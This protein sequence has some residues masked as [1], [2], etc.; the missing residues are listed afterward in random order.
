[1]DPLQ[2][3]L[4]QEMQVGLV[5]GMSPGMMAPAAGAGASRF[6]AMAGMYSS[7][8]AGNPLNDPSPL[9]PLNLPQY[10]LG[11]TLAAI[12][13]NAYLNSVMPQYGMLPVGNAGSYMQAYRTRE[14]MN[15]QNQLNFEVA[16]NDAPGIYRTARGIFSLAGMSMDAQQRQMAMRGAQTF[17]G[18][19][20][21]MEPFLPGI[22]DALA[23]PGGSIQMMTPQVL[24]ANRYQ[25]DPRTG[26]MGF[27]IDSNRDY[28]NSMYQT[29]FGADN[30]AKMQGFRAGDIGQLYRELSAEG[31]VSA[32]NLR[33]RTIR[34]LQR[35]RDEG[36]DI[37]A[38]ASQADIRFGAQDNFAALS[39]EDLTKF[40]QTDT[41]RQRLTQSDTQQIA[42]QL[43]GYTDSLAAIREVLGENG[44]QNAPIPKL[45]NHLKA[46]T[47]GQMQKF[48]PS[49]LNNMVRD[50][51]ALS[52]MSGKSIDQMIL[53]NQHANSMNTNILGVHGVHFNQATTNVGVTSGMAF[54]ERGGATGF[55]ALNREQVEQ[56]S[57][58]M[59][60]RSLG[61]EMF[62][63]MGAMT[64]IENAGGFADNE[65]GRAM[66][67]AIRAADMGSAT[68]SYTDDNGK[69]VTANTPTREFE[70][71]AL[72][73]RGAINGMDVSGFN[74]MLGDVTS[75]TRAMATAST[76]RKMAAFNQQANEINSV[77]ELTLVNRLAGDQQL[78]SQIAD[79]EARNKAASRLS[80]VAMNAIDNLSMPQLQDVR[81]RNQ[82]V[83]EALQ[84]EAGNQGLQLSDREAAAMADNAF[85]QRETVLNNRFGMDA[86]GYAMNF[87]KS[88]RDSR[89]EKQSV[90]SATAG[91]N[92][93]MSKLGN[94]GT[95]LQRFVS[96][97]QRQGDRGIKGDLATLFTDTFGQ[98]DLD[99]R[100]EEVAKPMEQI[101]T[102]K[103]TI[104]RL[105]ANL[106]GASPAE[107]EKILTEIEAE[108]KLLDKDVVVAQGIFDE[109]GLTEDKGHFNLEDLARGRQAANEIDQLSRTDAVRLLT[110]TS[111]AK[112]IPAE[113]DVLSRL[114]Q[115][116]DGRKLQPEERNRLRRQAEEQLIAEKQLKAL[117]VAGDTFQL[118]STG[119]AIKSD[120]RLPADLRDELAR[121]RQAGRADVVSRYVD[122]LATEQFYSPELRQ[123]AIKAHNTQ[124]GRQ[125]AADMA[126]NVMA[127]A[128][129]RRSFVTDP[130]A[131]S[132]G[133][134]P[135]LLAANQ[136]KM[137]EEDLQIMANKYFKGNVGR[138]LATGGVAMDE[139]G[140][141]TSE[142]EFAALTEDDKKNIKDRLKA[143]GRD[144][145]QVTSDDYRAYLSLKAKDHVATMR[146]SVNGM[147]GAAE[148]TYA[149]LLKVTDKTRELADRTIK[150]A[151]PEQLAGL[152]AMTTAAGMLGIKLSDITPDKQLGFD[153]NL[154]GGG[155]GVS[156]DHM[157]PKRREFYKLAQGLGGLSKLS[158]TQLDDL[159][160]LAKLSNTD[161]TEDA[162]KLGV[163]VDE[164][165]Q[166]L[167]GKAAPER[168]RLFGGD[169][170]QLRLAKE[171]NEQLAS[172]RNRY[173]NARIQLEREPTSEAA[174]QELNSLTL[175]IQ[176][177]ESDRNKRMRDAGFNPDD[178][179][180][181][182]KYNKMLESQGAVKLLEDRRLKR[183]GLRKKFKDGGV[184]DTA[185][186]SALE[187]QQNLLDLAAEQA[188]TATERDLGDASLNIIADLGGLE[189]VDARKGFLQGLKRGFGSSKNEEMLAS[190]LLRV[191]QVDTGDDRSYAIDKLTKLT[192]E[193]QSKDEAGRKAMAA[194][195]GM[196]PRE[197]NRMM[198]QTS[199]LNLGE[200]KDGERVDLREALNRSAGVDIAEEAK[201]EE[202]KK[203]Y[204]TGGT[205]T[206]QGDVVGQATVNEI[207]AVSGAR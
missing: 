127:L 42:D 116:S 203:M 22:T 150:D 205:L 29:M 10:G 21:T 183:E 51:Q 34:T 142:T 4:L 161:Y 206:I 14:Q 16:Q 112:L 133:G 72:A 91:L 32:G 2:L 115:L 190:A 163:T 109:M 179:K 174:K 11:G 78:V 113:Q 67:A 15:M 184:D 65:A 45:I 135:A 117:G 50:M 189:D 46:L 207:T 90:A 100:A 147:S 108:T 36:V 168:M 28:I 120:Q 18:F 39:N 56:A 27:G 64:R 111:Q 158:K 19:A 85:S 191:G 187:T 61:S 119:E 7:P 44:D 110:G 181:I 97:I 118:N 172:L 192:K 186:D 71:R 62:N 130:Y 134:A 136:N 171:E 99:S 193:F 156:T 128:D 198:A 169:M 20:P 95:I 196:D 24:E 6:N 41:I 96:A 164:Y 143:I 121:T 92:Q 122:S 126:Q 101:R 152:Q 141:K 153:S 175:Q 157:D 31:L 38:L 182:A 185:L 26:R 138:M 104:E 12:A 25:V 81:Q 40:R 68:Y 173:D 86:T 48:D 201:K 144:V 166:M 77:V 43:Q 178:P 98:F 160:A 107:R 80:S 83:A 75:N 54:A 9:A 30:I 88:V 53:M 103:A 180:D 79:R 93:A 140:L 177:R 162:E 59:F 17:A 87:G 125:A 57:M 165:K 129:V 197:L 49:Q 66:R 55:G 131:I 145:D 170:K 82:I 52:Q 202:E 194:Q 195:Y 47:S 89:M 5:P 105:T 167:E 114:N 70:L 35:A 200:L 74:Q 204:I 154:I 102:R 124:E 159:D 3:Q 188:K 58:N 148:K 23:G 37:G 63:A 13:G 176:K 94:K 106:R 149:N 33:D 132:R 84:A 60:S 69:T 151:T 199:F 123:A 137:A 155:H 1:M 73:S 8:I 139:A 76:G 146:D